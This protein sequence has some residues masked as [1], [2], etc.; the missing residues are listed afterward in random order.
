V[1]EADRYKQLA[2]A[3]LSAAAEK[4][5]NGK[6]KSALVVSPTHAEAA[7]ITQAIR[8]GLKAQEKLGKERIVEALVPAH[9]TEAERADP[10]VYEPGD[11]LQFHQNT[12]Q[13][14]KGSRLIVEEGVKAPTD[15]ANWFD[16]YR[17]A[18]LALAVGDRVRITA[19]GKTKD[20]KHRLNNGTLMTVEGFTARGDLVVDHGWVIAK[21]FG[22]IAHGYV[23]TSHASQGATVDKVFVGVSSESF[24]ATSQRTAYVAL[25]RG[26]EQA[27]LFTDDRKELLQA[28]SRPDDPLSATELAN[29]LPKKAS[30][31][32][33]SR[34]SALARRLAQAAGR[35]DSMTPDKAP[36]RDLE[37]DR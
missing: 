5:K 28:V 30:R 36:Q 6:P 35:N 15:V 8:D 16:V 9:L 14:K 20:G 22:H 23:V 34:L 12:S 11:M 27:Q 18:S 32:S 31:G 19:G 26:R 7:K 10:T 4:K 2:G 17:P 25:T 1:P 24:P 29:A 3:Y 13:H 21:E 33:R 37:H